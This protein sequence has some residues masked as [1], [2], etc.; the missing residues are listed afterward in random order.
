VLTGSASKIE[1]FHAAT[2]DELDWHACIR[3]DCAVR[4]RSSATSSPMPRGAKT[5]H[6]L[7]PGGPGLPLTKADLDLVYCEWMVAD[8]YDNLFLDEKFFSAD[9]TRILL[10]NRAAWDLGAEAAEDQ[11]AF[12][13]ATADATDESQL[14]RRNARVSLQGAFVNDRKHGFTVEIHPLDSLA[15]AL[16]ARGIPLS[17]GPED[18]EWPTRMITW[19]VAA[20][21]NSTFH[22][23]RQADYLKKE[24]A[25]TWYLPLP[26]EAAQPGA[27][28]TVAASF[29]GFT[30]HARGRGGMDEL[31]PTEDDHYQDYGLGGESHAIERDFT[32][33]S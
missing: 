11:N 8:G 13:G 16:D 7:V 3:L 4:D 28:V 32:N 10:L 9:L 26:S 24:R 27:V 22:Y 33:P 12:S 21:T 1:V 18:R 2:N 5:A 20:F 30:N 15:Y 14:C 29:P 19:R 6:Q 17:I 23:I 31:R 25:T